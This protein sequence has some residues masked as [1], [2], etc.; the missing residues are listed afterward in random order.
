MASQGLDVS[1][2]EVRSRTNTMEMISRLR[3]N[4][5]KDNTDKEDVGE[6]ITERDEIIIFWYSRC[7]Y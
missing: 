7:Y 5:R 3:K 2:K 1:V 4:P 6:Y